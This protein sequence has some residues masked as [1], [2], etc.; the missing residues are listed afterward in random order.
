MHTRILTPNVPSLYTS[1]CKDKRTC[2]D[3]TIPYPTPIN[4]NYEEWLSHYKN[5]LDSMY[6][7]TIEVL[8]PRYQKRC[9]DRE[10]FYYTI[11]KASSKHLAL[12]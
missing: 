10:S 4:S 6:S 12:L 2:K 5:Q 8:Y 9:P 3:N 11:Y 1:S 7:I